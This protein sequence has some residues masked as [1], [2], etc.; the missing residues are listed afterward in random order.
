MM[1]FPTGDHSRSDQRSRH[2][3]IRTEGLRG[4]RSPARDALSPPVEIWSPDALSPSTALRPPS[5]SALDDKVIWSLVDA[6]PD[7]IVLADETGQIL[8]VNRQTEELFGYDR[9]E[10][11]GRSVEQLLPE[12]F[13]SVHSAHRTR[14]RVEPHVRAMGAGLRLYGRRS[15]GREFPVEVSLSPVPTDDGLLIVAAIRDVTELVAA[16]ARAQEV[17]EILD[18]TRDAVSIFDAATLQYTYVNQGLLD[19]IGYQHDELL[20][21]TMLHIAPEF[22]E[23]QLRALLAPFEQGNTSS[24]TFTTLYRHRDGTDIPVEILM[25]AISGDDGRPHAYVNIARDIS[26]RLEA[27]VRQRRTEQRLRV[28]E[29]RERLARDLHDLVIQRLFATGMAAQSLH[30]R[31]DDPQLAERA[32]RIVDELDKTIREIRTVIFGL[33]TPTASEGSGLR[34]RLLAVIQEEQAALGFT[35]QVNFDGPIDTTAGDLAPEVLAVLREA[36]SNVA[37]HAGA[38]AVK[39]SVEAAEQLALRVTDDGVG[40]NPTH[41]PGNGLRNMASRAE[42]LEGT[43]ETRTA[44]QGGTVVEVRFPLPRS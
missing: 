18:A 25:Q 40:I 31:I 13:R 5:D 39:I 38:T 23:A 43:F 15:D 8:L 33:Q 16:E 2:H 32:E 29:D 14:Y 6:A 4:V 34:S 3:E 41:R 30:S 42:E 22:T 35:P 24:E 9:G 19:Q 28:L 26:E 7:G 10:L 1:A 27:E 44:P 20:Y 12:R 37:R 17:R 21:M 11:L 36:L